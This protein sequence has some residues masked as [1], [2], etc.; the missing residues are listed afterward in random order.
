[1]KTL[2]RIFILFLLPAGIIMTILYLYID[3]LFNDVKLNF[4]IKNIK[5]PDDFNSIIQSLNE[6]SEKKDLS[7]LATIKIE[8]DNINGNF[9]LKITNVNVDLYYQ[10]LLF[11]ESVRDENTLL[12][13]KGIKTNFEKQILIHINKTTQP[14]LTELLKG[15]P[16][17]LIY[18]I[19]ARFYK[20]PIGYKGNYKYKFS[21]NE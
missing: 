6:L 4:G 17:D 19:N 14:I 8:F 13:S 16:L 12:I 15:N 20:F 18:K 10:N 9:G 2:I 1:M 5:Y 21:L 3:K 11:I 7:I